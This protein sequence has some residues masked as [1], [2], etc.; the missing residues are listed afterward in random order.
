MTELL[1]DALT[2]QDWDAVQRIYAEGIATG[3]STF[4]TETPPRDRWFAAHRSPCNVVARAGKEI[5]G[6]AALTPISSRAVYAGVAEVSI[7]VAAAS[8]GQGVG[9]ILLRALIERSEQHGIWSLQAGVFPENTV[10]IA[11]HE[12]CGFRR[13][14]HRERI[15]RLHG[16]WR[17]VVL[18]ERRSARVGAD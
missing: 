2:E 10:S 11:L 16:R 13:I 7:Y 12:R 14:G 8:R 4:E 1:I 3:E 17:N 5:L 18:F 6:W 15:A 9:A